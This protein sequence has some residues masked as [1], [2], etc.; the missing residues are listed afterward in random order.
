[1]SI[2]KVAE[3]AGVSTA[4]VSRVLNGLPGVRPETVAQVRAAVSQLSY[5]PQRI[6][7]RKKKTAR[8]TA[9]RTGNIAV[10]TVGHDRTWLE[11]PVLASVLGG[12][13]RGANAQDLRL[14][15]CEMPEPTKLN[16][17][18]ME[19]Q[20]DGAVVFISSQVLTPQIENCLKAMQKYAPVVWA[21]GMEMALA[22]VDHVTPDNVSVGNLAFSYLK[23]LGCTRLAFLSANPSWP[24][25][26]LRGQAFTN[27]ALDA[28]LTPVVYLISDNERVIDA[29]GRR[30]VSAP[31]LEALI[32]RIAEADPRPD[33]IF[34]ENDFTTSYSYPL[35]AQYGLR[36]GKNLHVIS[37]DNEDARLSSLRPRP[38]S[39]DIGGEEV[40]FRAISRLMNRIER[41]N[42]PALVIQVTPRIHL[43][44]AD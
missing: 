41:P 32:Q 9:L 38:A 13:Q 11:R 17:V 43:P 2:V 25:M 35:F 33:G 36:I 40:G 8:G 24:L 15:L 12:I 29:Y 18:L 7:I 4:T 20:I 37:C 23:K 27:S 30:V 28:G 42:G 39:I 44:S 3:V 31:T 16:S 5:K 1:M 6:R 34:I 22:N 19:R 21:M 14:M 10:I 26:R